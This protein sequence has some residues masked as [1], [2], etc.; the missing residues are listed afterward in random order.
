MK[1]GN[2]VVIKFSYKMSLRPEV[3][4]ARRKYDEGDPVG[5]RFVTGLIDDVVESSKE[6]KYYIIK[7]TKIFESEIISFK[8]ILE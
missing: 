3:G 1:L 5:L 6:G 8:V 7:S 2:I 4:A